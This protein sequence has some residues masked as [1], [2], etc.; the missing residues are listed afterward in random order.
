MATEPAAWRRAGA[1]AAGSSLVADL[2]CEVGGLSYML[3]T[4]GQIRKILKLQ[5]APN[6][7]ITGTYDK[8]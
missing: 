8:A 7:R 6:D 4:C 3:Y 1:V 5:A 2:V